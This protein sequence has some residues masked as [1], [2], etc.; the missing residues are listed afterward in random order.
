MIILDENNDA[1]VID[2]IYVPTVSNFF[3]VLDLETLDYTL[4]P[5][6]VLEEAVCSTITLFT[7]GFAFN[8]PSHWNVLVYDAEDTMQLDVVAVSRVAG[9][10]FCAAICGPTEA[11]VTPGHLRVVNYIPLHT[12]VYPCLHKHQMLC[13]PI[14]PTKWISVAPSDSYNKYLKNRVIGDLF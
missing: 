9:K 13:H 4:T 6:T 3:W 11:R 1:V 14:S 5:I 10:D 8:I 2:N 7:H 12:N